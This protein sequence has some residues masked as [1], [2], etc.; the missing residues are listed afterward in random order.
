MGVLAY[1]VTS[2]GGLVF[3]PN[4]FNLPADAAFLTFVLSKPHLSCRI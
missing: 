1:A 2:F 3:L 4:C